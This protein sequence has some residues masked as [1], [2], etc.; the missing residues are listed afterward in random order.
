MTVTS[1]LSDM[2]APVPVIHVSPAGDGNLQSDM[3]LMGR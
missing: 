1:G 2:I 3:T